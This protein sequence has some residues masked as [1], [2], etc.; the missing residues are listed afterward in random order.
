MNRSE[1]AAAFSDWLNQGF[2]GHT[3]FLVDDIDAIQESAEMTNALAYQANTIIYTGRNP[4][5][6][7]NRRKKEEEVPLLDSDEI[8]LLL[9]R[10]VEQSS[11]SSRRIKYSEPDLTAVAEILLGHPL[12]TCN[13]VYFMTQELSHARRGI[14]PI[15]RFIDIFSSDQWELRKN[16][17]QF[18]PHSGVS[19]MQSFEL[20]LK[21]IQQEQSLSSPFLQIAAFLT[22]EAL[23]LRD[24]FLIERPWIAEFQPE[25][26]NHSI[27]TISEISLTKCLGSL[28]GTSLLMSSSHSD[29]LSLHPVWLEC[30]RQRV[31]HPGRL[32]ILRQIVLLIRVSLARNEEVELMTNFLDNCHSIC[33]AFRISEQELEPSL[34]VCQQLESIRKAHTGL[35]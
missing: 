31:E 35:A 28:E 29:T 2:N 1:R 19:V 12:A 33:K 21:R 22:N 20:S 11:V 26:P 30:L 15:T 3:L 17:L 8:V 27:F 6:F 24:F 18:K 34:P 23:D 16:F 4:Y 14:S 25:L 32:Q 9:K 7:P 5:A 10:T 13:A